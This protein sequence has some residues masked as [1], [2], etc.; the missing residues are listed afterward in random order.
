MHLNITQAVYDQPIA[1]IILN[2][3]NLK[4][5]PVK[6]GTRLGL[7]ALATFIQY[8]TGSPK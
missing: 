8:G 4:V 7:S 3:E 6:S 5:F 2:G 1:N